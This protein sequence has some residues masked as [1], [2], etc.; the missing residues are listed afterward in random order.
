[1]S[2]YNE[3]I[4][5]P[6]NASKIANA[7]SS[8][9]AAAVGLNKS[10]VLSNVLSSIGSA[11]S[12]VTSYVTNA[13]KSTPNATLGLAKDATTGI[14]DM[15]SYVASSV[16]SMGNAT[17]GLAKDATTGIADMGSYAAS[18]T[19]AMSNATLSF[20]SNLAAVAKNS[21]LEAAKN[22]SESAKL[23][24]SHESLKK[25]AEYAPYAAAGIAATGV[26]GAA[27]YGLY[28]Y[29][30]AELAD[31]ESDGDSCCDSES[32]PEEVIKVDPAPKTFLEKLADSWA[33]VVL[34]IQ[35]AI[36]SFKTMMSGAWNATVKGCQSAYA[37]TSTTISNGLSSLSKNADAGFAKVKSCFYPVSSAAVSTDPKVVEKPVEQE[38]AEQLDRADHSA[39]N[40]WF[41]PYIP[42]LF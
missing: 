39:K 1:M 28:H 12:N 20:V 33:Y 13:I 42:Q 40:S 3:T 31:D 4:M 8:L 41:T 11:A 38:Q 19:S 14:A 35:N 36:A 26:L 15:G 34:S 16:S 27:G 18:T 5:C 37:S 25:A 30:L 23:I 32:Q 24:A 17:V 21:T 10:T 6:V 29:H 7:T 22:I 9:S 2:Y